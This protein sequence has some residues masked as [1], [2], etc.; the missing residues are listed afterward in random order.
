MRNIRRTIAIG[1]LVA[2]AWALPP[3]KAQAQGYVTLGEGT[4]NMGTSGQS[5]YNIK[6]SGRRVQVMVLASDILTEGGAA[7]AIQRLAWNI[8]TTGTGAVNGYTIRMAHYT[9]GGDFFPGNNFFTP[10][11]WTTVYSGNFAPA[12]TGFQ[13]INFT[14]NFNWNGTQNIVVDVC[15]SGGTGSAGSILG[16]TRYHALVG[17]LTT[18]GGG[19]SLSGTG[20][21]HVRP[22]VRLFMATGSINGC[23]SAQGNSSNY[24]FPTST[25]TPS[26]TGTPQDVTTIGKPTDYSRLQLTGGTAYTF[27]SS[28]A[29]DH[30][31]IGNANGNQVLASGPSPVTFTPSSNMQVRFYTHLNSGCDWNSV[32]RTRRVQCGTAP[33]PPACATAPQ[34]APAAALCQSGPV[35]LSWAAV[36]GATG[37]D[38]YLNAGTTATTLVSSDQGGTTYAA[39]TL[40][41]G[42][43]SWR[44]VP[45]NASGPA[46]GCTTWGFSLQTPA[47]WYADADGDGYGDPAT[48]A[49]AC[50]QPAGHVANGDD[51]DDT[52]P[53]ITAVGQACDPGPGFENGVL[54]ADCDCVGTPACTTDLFVVNEQTTGA[55][56]VVWRIRDLATD[57]V[58][59]SGTFT[60]GQGSTATCV[61]DG[62]FRFEVENT[63]TGNAVG[64]YAL[65][66]AD[67]ERIIDNMGNLQLAPAGV[68]AIA[69]SEGFCLP[70]GA[71]RPIQTSCDRFWW[72]SG[73]YLVA[74][75]NPAVSAQFGTTNAT[76]GYEFWFYDPN[77]GLSFRKFRNH[78]TSDGFAPNNA[79]RAAHI[80]LNNWAAANHLQDN[81]LYNVRIRGVIDGTELPYGPACRVTLDPAQAACTPTGLND[82][83][84]H[85]NFSCGVARTFGGPNSMANRVYAR[86]VGGANKYEFEFSNPGEGYLVTVQSNT[87]IRHLNW[88]GQPPMNVGSIY[89]VRVRASKDGGTTWC[90]WGW[91]CDVT[92]APSAAPGGESLMM[93]HTGVSLWPNPNNGQQLWL[94]ID[95]LTDEV[96]TIAVDI[97]DLSGKRVV[98]R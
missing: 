84:G 82:I 41:P 65:R 55:N 91:A 79:V 71:D 64:G 87:V 4:V 6:N 24:Q 38:V 15:W 18:S 39:G 27:S 80:K 93:A 12:G 40:A 20:R 58:V 74:A 47:T 33:T 85:A 2:A 97:H 90:N 34:P 98:A 25:F 62:C 83:V 67:G 92:I 17:S 21:I 28:V 42:T 5:P 35:T 77:G 14:T 23:L 30:I 56:N 37:Y 50:A 70:L 57:A 61:P 54:N 95:G 22:Q 66:T 1:S 72:T 76:S 9:T 45:R 26:C 78:A 63:G 36:T 49:T 11:S 75:E 29:T 59:A 86:S 96:R 94:A 3:D 69:N 44:V 88:T 60:P 89:Q 73:N 46:T 8:A 10:S 68:S 48:T 13:D 31:T 16:D 7:G 19:C 51:C 43:Y 81:V 32:S 53:A 52:D